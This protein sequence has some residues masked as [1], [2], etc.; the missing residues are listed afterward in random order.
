MSNQVEVNFHPQ[1]L[2]QLLARLDKIVGALED[3]TLAWQ[4]YPRFVIIPIAADQDV[5]DDFIEAIAEAFS[6]IPEGGEF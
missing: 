6:P 3:M 4:T 1:A 2:G 5:S